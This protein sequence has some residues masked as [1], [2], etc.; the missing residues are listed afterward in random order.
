MC[1]CETPMIFFECV[2]SAQAWRIIISH[3]LVLILYLHIAFFRFIP[4]FIAARSYKSK[5]VWLAIAILFMLCGF[6]GYGT[7]VLAGWYPKI[8]YPLREYLSYG[9]IIFCIMFLYYTHDK[10]LQA[11]HE[12]VID[13]CLRTKENLRILKE[14]LESLD[15]D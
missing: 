1:D 9:D 7:V 14:K 11:I 2:G 8:A 15:N 10:R 6:C 4:A 5:F 12:D 3:T 13:T